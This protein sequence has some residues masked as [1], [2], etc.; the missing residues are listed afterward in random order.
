MFF[1]SNVLVTES[2]A[3][4]EPLSCFSDATDFPGWLDKRQ[5]LKSLE[6]LGGGCR[7]LISNS[8][9]KLDLSKS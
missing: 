3:R 2:A 5:F 7:K 4:G 8:V 6:A 9:F 1:I